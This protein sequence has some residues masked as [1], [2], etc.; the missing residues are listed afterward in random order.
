MPRRYFD[1]LPMYEKFHQASTVGSWVLGVGFLVLLVMF[2]RS[3]LNGKPAP[4]NPWGSAA[5][6]WQTPTPPPVFNFVKD[7]VL[8]RGQYDYQLA[9]EDELYDGFDDPMFPGV[10]RPGQTVKASKTAS[11]EKND[12]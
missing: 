8:T 12:E 7:P 3:L 5:L 4:R 11:K 6:E 9:T 1:Y 10:S 2:L